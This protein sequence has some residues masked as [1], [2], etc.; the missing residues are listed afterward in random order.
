V[1]HA[2][3]TTA[4]RLREQPGS[5]ALVSANGGFIT[6]HA[7]GVYATEPPAEPFRHADV[8][9][10]VDALPKRVLCEE[11]DAEIAIEAWTAM[12]DREGNPETGI[13]VGL[14]DDGQRAIGTTQD[15]DA[16]K[17]LVAED[18]LGRRAHVAPDGTA[19]LL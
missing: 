17:A 2:I 11:P 1:T 3:A 18:V 5:V 15:A 13:V 9:A 4:Q 14:L 19:T 7:F 16:L 6:K 8:Q 12:H 10:E